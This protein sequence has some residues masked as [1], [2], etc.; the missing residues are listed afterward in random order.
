M[1]ALIASI[2]ILHKNIE[3]KFSHLFAKSSVYSTELLY[4]LSFT[5]NFT[6]NDIVISKIVD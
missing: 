1:D 2:F 4:L 5:S 6:L 3:I